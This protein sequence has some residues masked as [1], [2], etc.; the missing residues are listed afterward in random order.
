[1]LAQFNSRPSPVAPFFGAKW[2]HTGSLTGTSKECFRN[3]AV[4]WPRASLTRKATLD[5]SSGVATPDGKLYLACSGVNK[6]TVV[7]AGK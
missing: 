5:I 3:L 1:M 2:R 7:N 4:F 6:V